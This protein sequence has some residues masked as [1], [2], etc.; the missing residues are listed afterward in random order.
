MKKID[1]SGEWSFCLDR[2][3]V[4][5]AS[6]YYNQTF[7]DRI[8]LPATVSTAG[9]GIP[10]KEENTGYLTD[11][12]EFEGYTWYSKTVE[13]ADVEEKEYFLVL[14]RTRVSHV[15]IDDIY[16]GTKNSFCTAH[17]YRLTPYITGKNRIRITIMIDNTSYPV[18]GGHMTSPDTQ[19]NWNGI[20]GEIGIEAYNKIYLSGVK[21]YP[22]SAKRSIK[23]EVT[24]DGVDHCILSAFVSDTEDS[25]IKKEFMKVEYVIQKGK[26]S[27]SYY[28]E[29]S[30]ITWSEH[31]PKLYQLN[32]EIML[33][34]QEIMLLDQEIME[35]YC[36][37]FGFRDFK[38]AGN[39]FEINGNRT[40]L[41]G[42]H[43]GLIFPMTGHAPT[44]LVSWLNVLGTSKEYGINHYRFHTCCPPEAAFLA[45]DLLGIYMEPE[46]PFWGTVTEEGDE[47]HD[48]AGQ[49]YLI[50][51]G[52]RI[53]DEFG[54]HPSFVMM[55]LGNELWGSKT[56][57]NQILGD[58]K[59][60][61]SR[62]LYTQGSNNFQFMP[63]I[64]ENE[65]F[66]C[67]VR[68]S[69]ERL[70]RGSYAMCD[71][72]QG[73]IQTSAPNTVFNYNQMIRPTVLSEAIGT[74]GMVMIQY[75]TDTKSVNVEAS[76]E[77]IPHLP[78][79]SHE[80]GQ[81]AMF[82]DFSEIKKYTGVLKARNLE[83]FQRRLE[84]K[85]LFS[86]VEQFFKA[87]GRFAAEC[88]KA[89]LETALRSSELAGMQI[90]DLQDFSGQGTALVGILNAFMEN[91]GVISAEEW[92]QFCGDRVILAELPKMVFTAGEEVNIGVKLATFHPQKLV[93]PR[94]NLSIT[95]GTD[96]IRSQEVVSQG[97][98]YCGV[99]HISNFIIKMPDISCPQKLKLNVRIIG[100]NIENNYDIWIYPEISLWIEN[101]T[102]ILDKVVMVTG[103]FSE[104]RNYLE[105]GKKVLLYPNC[106]DD[107]NSVQGTYCTDFWCYPMFRSISESMG[108]P[109]PVGTHG[110]LIQKDHSIFKFF[111]TKI[112]TTAQWYDIVSNSRAMI[113]DGSDIEPIVWTIDNFE[114]NHKLGNL[115]EAKV[116]VGRLFV[117]TSNLRKLQ[118]SYPA[119]WLEY[120]I[121]Q[122]MSSEEFEPN[123][124]IRI[125][126]LMNRRI[127]G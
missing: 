55:S 31:T 33:L 5:I 68:F 119:R 89:E 8:V 74:D 25:N 65:D 27:F 13:L 34:D 80:I 106:L 3:K 20:T 29:E 95:D 113:M 117:C 62:H 109:V 49:Q 48:E 108:K 37:L 2:E 64:L 1:L 96:T 9:K 14:E 50:E 41:R 28:L 76:K 19:T 7:Q 121:L 39:Y 88:Y 21:I 17:R 24:L 73:H 82:P 107:N 92:R 4:G 87:S 78:V 57:L 116:G 51:E 112:H 114:R 44:D 126:E 103:D 123:V 110:L 115:F 10:S 71:A 54:N 52:Y 23:V 59:S 40:F 127:E 18:K 124:E 97:E 104:A 111:P 69:K 11:L 30:V 86:K 26:N 60:Y 58:Y 70:F 32:L 15:W 66:F 22:D 85:G 101:S 63:C 79:V 53:L 36:Y 47:N 105:H 83:V 46:L 16:V 93:N 94:V 81:Y 122:Y 99:Y 118:D 45:A 84:E 102:E 91:K 38:T 12:Y 6:Q 72:P 43:D 61:D 90:L 75:G 120:S 100:Y 56:R 35:K 125:E 42:K 67:G 98:F 77:L